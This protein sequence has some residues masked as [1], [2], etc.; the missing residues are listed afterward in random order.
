MGKKLKG[1]KIEGDEELLEKLA[2]N[3]EKKGFKVIKLFGDPF[4]LE[5]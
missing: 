1:L 3:S 2:E 5:S 4:V